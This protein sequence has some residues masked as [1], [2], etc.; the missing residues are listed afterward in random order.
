[1]IRYVVALGLLLCSTSVALAQKAHEEHS[2]ERH[3]Q[4]EAARVA[5]ISSRL[6]LAPEQAQKFWPI[7]N[8]YAKKREAM[9]HQH[10]NVMQEV[11]EG[12]LTN[13]EARLAISEHLRLEKE[14]AALEEEYYGKRLQQVLEPR[15]VALLMK[16]EVEFKKMLLKRL[17]ENHAN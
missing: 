3:E 15:Q 10:R 1:M 8:E 17:K 14:E 2:K 5:H 7:Y 12:E 6:N 4:I 11:R 9:R 13:E 16:A